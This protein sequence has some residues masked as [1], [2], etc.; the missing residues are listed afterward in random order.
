MQE[1]KYS[2]QDDLGIHA[3]PAGLLTKLAKQYSSK[4]TISKGDKS[5]DA[6]KLI[7]LMAMGIKKND[8]VT[9]RAEGEDA[10]EA[11]AAM[12]DFLEKNL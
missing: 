9:V 3:R 5:A 6:T 12:K 7:A 10:R 8:E 11:V 4:I 2:I 1:F